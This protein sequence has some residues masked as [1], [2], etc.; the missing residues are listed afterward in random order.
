MVH[1]AQGTPPLT[2]RPTWGQSYDFRIYNYNASVVVGQS[3][4]QSRR[5]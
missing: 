2:P 3:F 5:K 4:F 1:V